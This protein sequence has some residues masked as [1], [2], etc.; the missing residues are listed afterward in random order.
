M[1][2]MKRL[3]IAALS[4]LTLV[5]CSSEPVDSVAQAQI[6]MIDDG[7]RGAM[8]LDICTEF[9]ELALYMPDDA[10]LDAGVALM[11]DVLDVPLRPAAEAHLR[12]V[13]ASCLLD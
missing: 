10:A 9:R 11:D 12:R 6:E 3:T 2:T 7:F 4:A 1:T 5:A 8:L 13:L